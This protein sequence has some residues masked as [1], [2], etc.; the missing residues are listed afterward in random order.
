METRV[1]VTGGFDS[2]FRGHEEISSRQFNYHG[3]GVRE[4][5]DDDSRQPAWSRVTGLIFQLSAAVSTVEI[6]TTEGE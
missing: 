3:G 5:L 4:L 6:D 1:K 2:G